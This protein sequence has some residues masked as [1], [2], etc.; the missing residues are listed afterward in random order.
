MVAKKSF[1]NLKQILHYLK[2]NRFYHNECNDGAYKTETKLYTHFLLVLEKSAFELTTKPNLL[3]LC[4]KRVY[5]ELLHYKTSDF[6]YRFLPIGES[7]G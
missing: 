1:L 2:A 5:V 3:D 4:Y 6:L 7:R